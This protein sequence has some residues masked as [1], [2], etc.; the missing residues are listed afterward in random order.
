MK[1]YIFTNS[2]GQHEIPAANKEAA[3]AKLAKVVKVPSACIA[4]SKGWNLK[5]TKS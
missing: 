5:G 2:N 1:I 4:Q 3:W